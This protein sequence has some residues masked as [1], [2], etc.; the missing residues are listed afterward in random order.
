MYSC[1]SS[2]ISNLFVN[3]LEISVI[4]KF[5]RNGEI[6]SWLRFADDIC[7]IAKKESVRKIKNKINSWDGSLKFTSVEMTDNLIYLDCE[8]YISELGKIEFKNY[9]KNGENTIFQ[10]F[11]HSVMSK[12][13]LISNL[14]GQFHRILDSSSN[15]ENFLDGL[16]KLK[17]IF[18][19]NQYPI[20]LIN[21]KVAR[22]LKNQ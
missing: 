15:E 19:R 17:I 20:A 22:F 14:F 9:R 11:R 18:L 13:Y 12:R 8:L 16:E 10:N 4:E 6:I 2:I 7:C 21:K 5:Q 1:L 3:L